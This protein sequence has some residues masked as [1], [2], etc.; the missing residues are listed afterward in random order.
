[1]SWSCRVKRAAFLACL[2]LSLP[3]SSGYS[4]ENE[5][6]LQRVTDS[7][8]DGLQAQQP[9]WS[10][11]GIPLLAYE[12]TDRARMTLLKTVAFLNG[13]LSSSLVPASS[14]G[15][16]SSFGVGQQRADSSVGWWPGRRD[17]TF[18]RHLDGVGLMHYDGSVREVPGLPEG[19]V[20]EAS[21]TPQ[22][23]ALL[24]SISTGETTTLYRMPLGGEKGRELV[25]SP[26][27]V[28]SMVH[29]SD[30]P[31]IT[32]IGTDRG[33]TELLQFSSTTGKIELAR[34]YPDYELLSLSASSNEDV[35]LAYARANRPGSSAG[36]GY[37]LLELQT[38][39]EN[40]EVKVLA[41]DLYL[42]PG[43]SP[44]PA[45]GAG[46]QE[47]YF[48]K[49]DPQGGNPIVRLNL[50]SGR[51]EPLTLTTRG[52]QE[53]AVGEFK[54]ENGK[55]VSWIAVIAVGDESGEDV[56]NHLYVGPLGPWTGWKN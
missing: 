31:T 11:S 20:L 1:M 29:L 53:V 3:F 10:T 55:K 23:D 5:V 38:A 33:V 12:V 19:E 32:A 43:L 13:S 47:V 54:D 18:I 30:G 45:L 28:H 52:H 42:P 16:L 6:A 8:H 7:E 48:V 21:M 35:V 26:R 2:V 25:R 24:L 17:F 41:T 44:R 56:A 9:I 49:S 14:A 40:T 4:A 34:S 22:A 37:V 27:V 15:R 46:G 50:A 36:S 39:R 51:T